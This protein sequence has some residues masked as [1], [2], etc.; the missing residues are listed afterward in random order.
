MKKWYQESYFNRANW[1]LENFAKLGLNSD[2]TL[3]I[4]QLDLAASCHKRVNY[5]YLSAKLGKSTKE[6]DKLIADL[7]ARKYLKLTP[8]KSG[9]SFDITPIFEF[10]P[11][12]YEIA[13]NDDI[14][15]VVS[16]VFGKPLAP[17]ELQKMNDLINEYSRDSFIQAL[18]EAESQ[19]VFKMSYIE[20][21][22]RNEKRSEDK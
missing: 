6:I 2:E 14:Y 20:T 19:R 5:D 8:N 3:L 18:R 11:Q 22:L 1:I 10:D 15:D 12:K 4:L 13:R 21:I 7:S 9:V 16:E 17:M